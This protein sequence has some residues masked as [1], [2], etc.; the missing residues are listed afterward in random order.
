MGKGMNIDVSSVRWVQGTCE[1]GG[2]GAGAEMV[3]AIQMSIICSA[4]EE[5]KTMPVTVGDRDSWLSHQPLPVIQYEVTSWPKSE[6]ES[7]GGRK[8]TRQ[9]KTTQ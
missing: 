3:A 2:G 8:K 5:G 9:K 7:G 6:K 1:V 4:S